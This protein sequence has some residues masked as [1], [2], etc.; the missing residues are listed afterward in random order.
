MKKRAE[1]RHRN[2]TFK[3]TTVSAAAH[4]FRCVRRGPFT[5]RRTFQRSGNTTSRSTGSGL[6]RSTWAKS[7]TGEVCPASAEET[8]YALIVDNRRY[9]KNALFFALRTHS[10]VIR[11]LLRAF[12]LMTI[13]MVG[14]GPSP[15]GFRFMQRLHMLLFTLAAARIGNQILSQL[16]QLGRCFFNLLN[17]LL[18]VS[19]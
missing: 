13:L 3:Q 14:G 2:S 4:V 6:P 12:A 10:S 7:K 5:R 9:H 17:T 18:G 8:K 16:F 11:D 1:W 15:N 19:W